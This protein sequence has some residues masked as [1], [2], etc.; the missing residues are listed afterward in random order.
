[1]CDVIGNIGK[2]RVLVGENVCVRFGKILRVWVIW[3]D[4][5]V[6]VGFEGFWWDLKGFG[7]M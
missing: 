7:G 3:W 6:L 1:M 4:L 2:E 5:K